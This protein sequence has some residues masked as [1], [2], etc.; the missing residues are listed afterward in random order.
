LSCLNQ[1]RDLCCADGVEYVWNE[2][3]N[4]PADDQCYG[5]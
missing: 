2:N 1:V 5:C 4:R 3:Q